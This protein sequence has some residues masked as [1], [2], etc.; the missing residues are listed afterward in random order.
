MDAG[1]LQSHL[2]Q[3]VVY[4]GELGVAPFR[5]QQM[6]DRSRVIAGLLQLVGGFKMRAGAGIEVRRPCLGKLREGSIEGFEITIRD[7]ERVG[8]L[9]GVERPQNSHPPIEPLAPFLNF[10]AQRIEAGIGRKGR[11]SGF[12]QRVCL[13]EDAHFGIAFAPRSRARGDARR[14]KCAYGF[15]GCAGG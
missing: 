15:S 1:G 3:Q 10:G 13:V 2:F 12:G 5:N 6:A 14:Q 8:L 9:A 4:T 11:L 7:E